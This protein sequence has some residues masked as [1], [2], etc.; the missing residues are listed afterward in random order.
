MKTYSINSYDVN[1]TYDCC[2]E[3]DNCL[4]DFAKILFKEGFI[5]VSTVY[6]KESDAMKY[7]YTISANKK[8]I[9]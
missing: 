2:N 5:S 4:L 8:M 1:C 7:E 9:I 6:D 3:M